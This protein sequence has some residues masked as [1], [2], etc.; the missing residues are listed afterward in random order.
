MEISSKKIRKTK[1][2]IILAS[3]MFIVAVKNF[4][5]ERHFLVTLFAVEKE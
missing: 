2:T 1:N 4:S 5:S 3:L